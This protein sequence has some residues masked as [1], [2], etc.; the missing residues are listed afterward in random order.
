MI[1]E[2][3]R[4]SSLSW[5]KLLVASI[6]DPHEL[7]TTLKLE[8]FF[9]AVSWKAIDKFPLRVSRSFVSRME[10]GNIHDPL[11]RQVLP[12][13]DELALQAGY[14]S[15]PVD[16]QAAS[17]V[18]GLLHKYHGRVLLILTGSCAINCRY[19]FR[20]EFPY[21]ANNPGQLGWQQAIDY[22]AA[23]TTIE[24]VILSG[25][26][27]LIMPDKLL[28]KLSAALNAIPHLTSLRIHTRLPVLLPERI[29]TEFITWFTGS[30]LQ[31]I[32]V[33][34]INHA[35]EIDQQV[36]QAMLK[37]YDAGVTLFNQSVLLRGVNDSA[38]ALITLSKKLFSIGI[39]PYYL[40][41][42][43]KVSG[44]AHFEVPDAEAKRLW[45]QIAH[46]LPGYLVPK[47]VR[48]EPG[49]PAK[50]VI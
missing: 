4:N 22:I 48:E 50:T 9:S 8:P 1:L 29:T 16:E 27:P 43:D 11:L 36:T 31:P 6:A 34:H 38:D 44:T 46:K 41:L 33:T 30:R 45:Q 18:P 28:A 26:D 2:N 7:L 21:T 40:H 35:N 37:L 32:L 42:L 13:T 12:L 20:R 23:D 15:D 19:C 3:L 25:G 49:M 10:P 24:E 17:R 5:Q 14:S 39:I 47:L